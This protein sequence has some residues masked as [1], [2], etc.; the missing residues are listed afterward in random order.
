ML[1]CNC[2]IC[3]KE[4]K[5][6][7][8]RPRKYCSFACYGISKD[9]GIYYKFVKINGKRMLAHRAVMEEYL[10]RSLNSNEHVHH[11]NGDKRDNR[12]E[13]LELLTQSEHC[14]RTALNKTPEQIDN[15]RYSQLGKKHTEERLRRLSEI[16]TGWKQTKESREKISATLKGRI[17]TDEW[18]KKLS[19]SM[20]KRWA[21]K[22]SHNH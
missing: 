20:K 1:T 17:F 14:R 8:N 12:I 6:S 10:G 13:N 2:I 11:I 7:S 5:Y 16:R 18:R 9:R 4:I 15:F 19:V 3:G 22:N 21:E